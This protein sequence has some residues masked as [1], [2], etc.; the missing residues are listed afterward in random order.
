MWQYFRNEPAL[1][2]DNIID[3]DGDNIADPFRFK[4]IVTG[5]TNNVGAKDLE[6]A[7][8]LKCLGNFRRIFEML[9][10]N[11][12]THLILTPNGL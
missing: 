4:P 10:I 11:C 5:T 2:D 12:E 1:N 6:I 3:F 8:L 7:L 9:V